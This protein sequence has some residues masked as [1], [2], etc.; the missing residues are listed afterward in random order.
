MPSGVIAGWLGSDFSSP[1]CTL[2]ACVTVL[3][4]MVNTET[5]PSFRFAA[6]A[7]VPC[8][9]IEMPA[10][11]APA[12]SVAITR[13]GE[14]CKSITDTLLSG[15]CFAPSSRVA[16][17]TSAIDSSGA[18]ATESGGPNTLEGALISA[19]SRGGDARR[20]M[21]ATVSGAAF[22]ATFTTPASST[23][24]LSFAETAR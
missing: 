12:S 19:T 3:P 23:A 13:G 22:V 18:T 1:S 4:L 11:P 8:W 10:T 5:V 17:V 24:L 20:S 14:A 9:V 21:I 7:S 16:A 2:P 6:S 15:T